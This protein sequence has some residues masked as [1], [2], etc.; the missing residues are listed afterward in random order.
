MTVRIPENGNTWLS[1]ASL[2]TGAWLDATLGADR[3][4]AM[5]N[6]IPEDRHPN[7]DGGDG[8]SAETICEWLSSVEGCEYIEIERDNV[9]NRENDFSDVF[10]FTV[11]APAETEEWYYADR[12]YIATCR[13][14]GGDVRGNYASP[15]IRR[16]DNVAETGFLDWLLG[17]TVGG[18]GIRDSED[19]S[20]RFSPGY[21]QNPGCTLASEYGEAGEWRDG[22]F[23][24]T[25]SDGR[26]TGVHA[27]PYSRYSI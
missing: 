5:Y 26:P 1:D 22:A 27:T 16:A 17:W 23:Y 9:Y 24:F 13:H 8:G 3:S 19:A 20:E 4:E 10:T 21:S 18:E 2:E 7:W 15:E 12:V 25:D 6:A 14:L 11:Y